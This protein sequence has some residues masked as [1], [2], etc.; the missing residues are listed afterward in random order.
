MDIISPGFV[1]VFMFTL[2]RLG[3]LPVI[4]YLFVTVMP[5]NWCQNFFPAQCL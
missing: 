4:V 2:S 1:Y 5:L 3:L